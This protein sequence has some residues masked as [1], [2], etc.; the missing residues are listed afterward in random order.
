MSQSADVAV[1]VDAATGR[2]TYVSPSVTRLFGWQPEQL[3][4]RLARSLTHPEDIHRLQAAFVTT[5]ADPGYHPT[6]EFR[7]GCADG[8][9]RWVEETIS[10]LAA[11]RG[12][13]GLVANIRDIT[14]RRATETALRESDLRYRLIAETAQEGIWAC[15]HDG[16]TLFANETLAGLL[17]WSL[18]DI[19]ALP[20]HDL[21]SGMSRDEIMG[22]QRRRGDDG[23]EIFEQLQIR[24]DGSS[25]ILRFSAVAFVEDGVELGALAM[26]SDVTDARMAEQE[27]RRRAFHDSLTGLANRASLIER[28][29]AA[30][31]DGDPQSAGTVAVLVCDLDQFKLINDSFGHAAGDELLIEIARRWQKVLG[32]ND[33]L[34]RLGGDE[35]VVVCNRSGEAAARST[36]SNLLRALELPVNLAGRPVAVSASVGIALC[37][38]IAPG[39]EA[40]T[41]L[42]YADAA[43]YSAKSQGRGRTAVFTSELA[44]QAQM[45]LE[46][47]ND[48]KDALAAEELGPGVPTSRR[49]GHR[50]DAGRRSAVPLGTSEAG[51]RRPG[52]VHLDGRGDRA[53]RTA[54][55]MGAA[56][57]V[58]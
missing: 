12:V 19:Y 39:V 47:F 9:Y 29:S 28:L 35:F 27:L 48:L 30:L 7:L 40:A 56:P 53:H 18:S 5:T 2:I 23:T 58:P 54:G 6:V 43:M 3:L 1:I 49:A 50:T 42:R 32:P 4:G 31:R 45:R 52:R 17:G 16:R 36:A 21:L 51:L 15:G 26:I 25:R 41:L 10:N 33:T 46:L 55:P 20:S 22:R 24:P 37:D 13:D 44:D 34:A 14:D 8:S 57:G 11:V 38:A